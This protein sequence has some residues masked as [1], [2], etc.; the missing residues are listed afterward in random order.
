MNNNTTECVLIDN[1]N[2]KIMSQALNVNEEEQD[3]L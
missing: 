3:L 1:A 2:D